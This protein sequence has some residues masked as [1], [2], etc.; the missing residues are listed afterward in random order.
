M[1]TQDTYRT[2]LAD[3]LGINADRISLYWKGRV[4]LYAVLKAMGLGPGDEVIL[5]AFT[6]VVVPNA[7]LYTGATPVYVDINPNSLCCDVQSIEKAITPKTKAILI[8]N[9]LGLSYEVHEIGSLAK[10]RG[11]Y[12]IEDCT[13][14]FGGKYQGQ[15]N[16]LMS[17]AAF[18]SSQWNKPFS[19][20][21]GGMLVINHRAL[22]EP[23]QKINA[24]LVAPS[25]KDR[26]VLSALIWARTYLLK[27]YTY[28]TL[29]RWY[30]WMSNKGWVVGSSS[31]E[32]LVGTTMPEGYVKGMSLVQCRK[33][34]KSLKSLQKA[35]LLRKNNAL[36]V[37]D[38]LVEHHKMC[39]PQPLMEDHA[40]LKYPVL[41]KDREAF[42]EKA[43]KA[44]LPL[45]DWFISPLHPVKSSLVPWGL[46]INQYPHA[47]YISQHIV[48]LPLE[49][50]LSRLMNFLEL[51]QNEIL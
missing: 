20:G 18:F 11:I 24:T 45:G 43:E 7:I 12:T 44:R 49:G 9:M 10:A 33:G 26:V 16:G 36:K 21:I 38:W 46:N 6:C 4:G 15:V 27:G 42:I 37:H 32:E 19:T 35:M 47:R 25:F 1:S 48:N 22:K 30:R 29:L 34:I 14:G 2:D 5:P 51:Y 40:F 39:V 8:Q 31:S 17:D 3:F 13:H 28:W 50:D 41:V 23:L